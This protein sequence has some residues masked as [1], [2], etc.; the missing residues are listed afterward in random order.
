[1]QFRIEK[2]DCFLHILHALIMVTSMNISH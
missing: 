1:L 2:R